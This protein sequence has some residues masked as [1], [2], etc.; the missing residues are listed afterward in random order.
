MALGCSRAPLLLGCLTLSC[1]SG[2]TSV[3]LL[4]EGPP[5]VTVAS[6]VA[7]VALEGVDG[8][9]PQSLPAAGGAP[10]LPGTVLIPLPD[11]A[12]AV[13]VTL[14]GVGDDGEPLHAAG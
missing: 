5:N 11:R 12:Q 9:T 6:L 4:I 13:T 10:R 1:V 2:P 8:G 7:R 14:D 3:R